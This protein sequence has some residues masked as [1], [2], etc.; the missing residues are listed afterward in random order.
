[1]SAADGPAPAPFRLD[2]FNFLAAS[3]LIQ[4]RAMPRRAT[5]LRW[6]ALIGLSIGM[7]VIVVGAIH[8]NRPAFY[9]AGLLVLAAIG[10]LALV[11]RQVSAHFNRLFLSGA[12]IGG[13]CR[14]VPAAD[15][16]HVTTDLS[17]SVF[18]WAGITAVVP[19]G[20]GLLV[21]L[22]PL[23]YLPIPAGAFATTEARDAFAA[24]LRS[25]SLAAKGP[26]S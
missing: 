9:G 16:L 6:V 17:R 13:T 8:H 19:H 10:L 4:R 11:S 20:S 21:L 3:R 23:H 1:M 12:T 18:A 24:D 26:A 5:A 22:G 7:S 15:G 2:G 25:R 14:V